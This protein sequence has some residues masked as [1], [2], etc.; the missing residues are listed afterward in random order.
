MHVPCTTPQANHHTVH[1]PALNLM[2]NDYN[3]ATGS[4]KQSV[5]ATQE[6]FVNIYNNAGTYYSES[7]P[8]LRISAIPKYPDI[9][10]QCR[11]PGLMKPVDQPFWSE[12]LVSMSQVAL[13][14]R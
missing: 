12:A 10:F 8:R 1:P 2:W 13:R 11:L 4:T 3:F 5:L 6:S 7:V 14:L 9:V